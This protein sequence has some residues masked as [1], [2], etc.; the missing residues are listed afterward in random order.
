MAALP[1][2]MMLSLTSRPLCR[3]TLALVLDRRLDPDNQ[4]IDIN[5][6]LQRLYSSSSHSYVRVSA[7]VCVCAPVDTFR[8]ELDRRSRPVKGQGHQRSILID[9]EGKG[10]G[11]TQLDRRKPSRECICVSWRGV[12]P[13]KWEQ[14]R[15]EGDASS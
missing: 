5:Q 15:S 3:S 14:C 7:R 11:S 2:E 1:L 9:S 10:K 13:D 6:S 8:A 4:A 12:E